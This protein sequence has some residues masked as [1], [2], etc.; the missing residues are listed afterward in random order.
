M[1]VVYRG[2]VNIPKERLS[3]QDTAFIFDQIGVHVQTKILSFI[4]S[5]CMTRADKEI[6]AVTSTDLILFSDANLYNIPL[7]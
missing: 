5:V 4:Y 7:L 2:T 3:T 1:D 6:T